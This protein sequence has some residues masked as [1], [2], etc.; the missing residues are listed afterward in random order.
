MAQA[1]ATFD[2]IRLLMFSMGPLRAFQA[3]RVCKLWKIAA[4]EIHKQAAY[5]AEAVRLVKRLNDNYVSMPVAT[6]LHCEPHTLGKLALAECVVQ[7]LEE[8]QKYLMSSSHINVDPN[9]WHTEGA[10][11]LVAA[12]YQTEFEDPSEHQTH[13]QLSFGHLMDVIPCNHFNFADLQARNAVHGNCDCFSRSGIRYHSRA[14]YTLRCRLIKSNYATQ[15]IHDYVKRHPES[16]YA[17]SLPRFGIGFSQILKQIDQPEVDVYAMPKMLQRVLG[18]GLDTTTTTEVHTQTPV[19]AR[20]M[21]RRTR[22]V[23]NDDDDDRHAMKHVIEARPR[24][25]IMQYVIRAHRYAWRL[26]ACR[27]DESHVAYPYGTAV[28]AIIESEDE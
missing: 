21:R 27:G 10:E 5:R 24:A 25:S 3:R 18:L 12:L 14:C 23:L 13:I 15:L 11:R 4:E 26:L 17:P 7:H 20:S 2:I 6:L 19:R 1:L 16:F 22:I 28:G 8:L 9:R